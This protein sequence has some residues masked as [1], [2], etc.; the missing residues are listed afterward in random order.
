MIEN[1]KVIEKIDLADFKTR[2][3]YKLLYDLLFKCKKT[4]LPN[5]K[6]VF[7]HDETEFYHLNSNVGFAI[8]NLFCLLSKVDI[9]LSA[10]CFVTTN[11][12][13]EKS[14][15]NFIVDDNDKPIII[16][17]LV[18]EMTYSNF[19]NFK[20]IV[21]DTSNIN[22]K[23]LCMIG[24]PREHRLYLYNFFQ[25][26]NYFDDIELSFNDKNNPMLSQTHIEIKNKKYNLDKNILSSIS[27]QQLDELG[28]VFASTVLSNQNWAL[29][30]RNKLIRKLAEMPLNIIQNSKH[31]KS[32]DGVFYNNFAIDI[33]SET[34]FDYPHAFVSEKTL[35]PLVLKT[36]FIAVGPHNFLEYLHSFGFTTFGDIWS[37]DYDKIKDPQDRF[38]ACT[39]TIESVLS[40]PLDEI[41][42]IISE[43]EPRL[44]KN[45][46]ILLDYIENTFKPLYNNLGLINFSEKKLK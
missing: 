4:F 45:R 28:L 40:L 10:T 6:I 37:E 38:E 46:Q 1:I 5:E 14:I 15:E 22:F 13:L 42:S 25:N 8:Y 30:P 44:E 11:N 39:K 34:A 26:S 36:P 21:P 17:T 23:A 24:T 7:V 33:V 29:F 19:C 31:I 41:K 3:D 27:D 32:K 43:I 9:P 2:N 35:R 12:N 18:S 20:N 16:P